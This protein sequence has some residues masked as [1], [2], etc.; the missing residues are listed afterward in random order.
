[1][2]TTQNT[3]NNTH[4]HKLLFINFPET[5]ARQTTTGPSQIYVRSVSNLRQK[6]QQ[7]V[8]SGAGASIHLQPGVIFQ[9]G[10]EP[11][12]CN[13]SVDMALASIYVGATLDAEKLSRVVEITNGCRLT[14]RRLNLL[15]GNSMEVCARPVLALMNS[16]VESVAKC[17]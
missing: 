2:H 4:T 11:L 16:N 10:G 1:M 5:P 8:A 9:L 14:L 3:Q 7:S 17:A 15:N 13:T 12:R 6:F